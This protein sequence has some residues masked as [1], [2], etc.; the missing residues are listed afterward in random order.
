MK[1]E[2]SRH[3][4]G[5]SSSQATERS[6]LSS[7]T[8]S[9]AVASPSTSTD[10]T[11]SRSGRSKRS[12]SLAGPVTRTSSLL[13]S[14]DE[15]ECRPPRKIDRR[16]RRNRSMSV[17]VGMNGKIW[18][19]EGAAK[20]AEGQ[21]ANAVA[22]DEETVETIAQNYYPEGGWGWGVTACATWV[23]HLLVGGH[24]GSVGV[25]GFAAVQNFRADTFD[26][27]KNTRFRNSRGSELRFP[28]FPRLI[29]SRARLTICDP[30]DAYRASSE[31]I[32]RTD[33]LV[34]LK[35]E[36]SCSCC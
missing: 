27:G 11:A 14:G 16:T 35:R 23:H 28:T 20:P 29:G 6:F 21:H 2:L 36:I 32:L 22:M 19:Q 3:S 9:H 25:I 1:E 7:P 18:T 17:V 33:F 31:N 24:I 13:S 26:S 30:S 5:G 34:Q 4:S 8:G 12:N 10:S 15:E